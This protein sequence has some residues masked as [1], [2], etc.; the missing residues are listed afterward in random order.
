MPDL[1]DEP[2]AGAENWEPVQ[3]DAEDGDQQQRGDE[4][5]YP[6]ADRLC[7]HYRRPDGPSLECRDSAREHAD[8]NDQQ[9]AHADEDQRR[10]DPWRHHGG[11]ALT[12]DVGG[13]EVSPDRMPEP[14]DVLHHEW[15][16][17]VVTRLEQRPGMRIDRATGGERRDGTSRREE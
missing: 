9:G 2:R 7:N 4:G 13:P 8:H 11:H 6:E 14:V 5:R 12:L 1:V 16:V 15:R 3:L 10:R 17:E